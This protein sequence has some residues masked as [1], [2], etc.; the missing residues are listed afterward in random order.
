MNPKNRRESFVFYRSFI[1][2]LKMLTSEQ[3]QSLVIAMGD[4]ALDFSEPKFDDVMCKTLWLSIK[5]QLDAN[6]RKYENGKKG[7][8]PKGNRNNPNGRRGKTIEEAPITSEKEINDQV[9]PTL[10]DVAKYIK[11]EGLMVQPEVF[12]NYYKARGWRSGITPITDWKALLR[13]WHLNENDK[14]MLTTMKSGLGIG[15]IIK[16]GIRTYGTSGI[17]VPDDAPPRPSNRFWWNATTQAW[18]DSI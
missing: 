12:F 18:D 9:T 16:D 7:G 3:V 8:A 14:N 1:D 6:I 4:Y 11:S 15:E 2:V 10:N 5:P 17:I 13:T